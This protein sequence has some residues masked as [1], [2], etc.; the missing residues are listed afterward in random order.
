M[1]SVAVTP[2]D[3]QA[4]SMILKHR[5]MLVA[6]RIQPI[7]ALRGHAAEYGVIAAKGTVQVAALLD[8]L[9]T[10]AA[11]PATAQAMFAQMG[12]TLRP[13]TSR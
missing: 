7:N 3:Q 6:Q 1:P 13:W 12:A 5:E 8:K 11:I 10:D 9:A 4:S 2:L